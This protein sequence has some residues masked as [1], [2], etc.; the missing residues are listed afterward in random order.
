MAGKEKGGATARSAAV[1]EEAAL[2]RALATGSESA[3]QDVWARYG[4]YLLRVC[5][6]VMRNPHDAEEVHNLV[7]VAAWQKLPQHAPAIENLKAW[8]GRLARNLCL[9]E[10]RRRQR[11]EALFA[12][13]EVVFPDPAL[14]RD[15]A[16]LTPESQLLAAEL[17]GV[18]ER[19]LQGL[20][21][22]LRETAALCFVEALDYG[23]ICDRLG[24]Q[25]AN[26]R[27][28]IEKA[29]RHLQAELARYAGEDVCAKGAGQ[30][31]Q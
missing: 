26:A 15:E 24:I 16:M 8:L 9:D 19:A 25:R 5:L 17:N 11:R 10:Q 27:K 18:A 20:P 13:L 12:S 30:G 22:T 2:L 28:R 3:F 21:L 4:D 31:Q 7:A 23:A 6:A 1:A 14:V 29:R